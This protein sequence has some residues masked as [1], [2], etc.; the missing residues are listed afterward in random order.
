[1]VKY[2]RSKA[3]DFGIDEKCIKMDEFDILVNEPEALK[4]EFFH[5]KNENQNQN[6]DFIASFKKKNPRM[7][8]SFAFAFCFCLF[9]IASL[10]ILRLG[11][12]LKPIL[13]HE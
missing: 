8:V 2:I 12:G 7:T 3:I 6:W 4:L 5:S 1:M 9:L 11:R 10:N 13:F